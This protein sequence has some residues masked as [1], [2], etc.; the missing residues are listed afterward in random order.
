[1]GVSA[2]PR[3]LVWWQDRALPLFFRY[4]G[5]CRSLV[6]P[7]LSCG[8]YKYLQLDLVHSVTRRGQQVSLSLLD[9]DRRT[10]HAAENPGRDPGDR[11][12]SFQ[13]HGS[14]CAYS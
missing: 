11:N 3:G 4:A 1:M 14:A 12:C 9:R 2:W 13:V 8:M 10:T 5:T 6:W 7:C